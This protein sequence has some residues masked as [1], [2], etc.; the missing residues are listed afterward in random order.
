MAQNAPDQERFDSGNV[1]DAAPDTRA[2]R[3]EI[4][5]ARARPGPDRASERGRSGAKLREAS[6][7]GTR[8]VR[9]TNQAASLTENGLVDEPAHALFCAP[10]ERDDERV[11][12]G[13]EL[14]GEQGLDVL[15]EQGLRGTGAWLPLS[16][17][18]SANTG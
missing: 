8:P 2:H 11:R 1:E 3:G 17:W 6:D 16:F 9:E 15:A 4:G 5:W 10:I 7:V 12:D 13:S 14:G 18:L